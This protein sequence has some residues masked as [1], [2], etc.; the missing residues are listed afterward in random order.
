MHRR[1]F[2][3]REAAE[4]L[5]WDETYVSKLLSGARVPG[6]DNAI[7]LERMTGIPVERW[8]STELDK[9][10]ASVAAKRR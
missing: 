2:M 7:H 8:A 5:G 1:K 3:Q 10:D 6:L 9:D 4:Y